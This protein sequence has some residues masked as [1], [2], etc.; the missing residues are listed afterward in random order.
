M[1]DLKEKYLQLWGRLT[2]RQHYMAVG[3]AVLLVVAIVAASFAFGGKPDMVPL[4]TNMETKDAG[5]VAAK[6]KENKVD[7]EVQETK[8]G[9]TIM[10][11]AAD[12]HD[13]RLSL[14]TEGLPR[15]NKG[16]EIFDDSKLGV[17]EFQ[18][19]VN[20]LQAL[21]G[22]LTR[23][24]EQIA[25][26]EK[27][28]V[29]IVLPEDSLYKRN[30]KPATASIMLKLRPN[31]ELNKKE[32]K[33]IVNLA[34]RSIQGLLPENITVVDETGRILNDPDD[35]DEENNI[36]QKTMTQLDMTRKV[37]ER[38]QKDVQTM[39][40]QALGEGHSYVRVNVELDFDQ[41]Q[42]DRQTYTPV[43]DDSGIIRS[44]Q[45]INETYSGTSTAPG[46]PAG[47]QSNVPGYVAEEN[48]SN[49]NYA[50]K[51]TTKNYEVNEAKEKTVA[52]PGSIKRV[53]IAVLV[54]EDI[55]QAQQESI[56][57]SVASAVGI[58]PDRGDTV[59][60]EPLPFSTEVADRRAAEE[61]AA[62]NAENMQIALIVGL[63]LLIIGGVA[64][65]FYW[66][67]KKR[68]EAEQAAMEEAMRKAE[69]ERLRA[70]AERAARLES[71]ELEPEEMTQEEQEHL[72]ERQTI[73][74]LIR[75]KPAEM[76]MLVKTW[77]SE[78]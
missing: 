64:G 63:I 44:E 37:Q 77:L 45:T 9:T 23:T 49:A 12:V 19:K 72:S 22:E 25:A 74:D 50:K 47:T 73:E 7:Y 71:G 20:Y 38:M 65:Y 42:T 70:E 43:V 2:K 41:R 28:R 13:A 36:T 18:N 5:E 56:Q 14:A 34:S 69:E 33:G 31:M 21:Q 3:G 26:V 59:S 75:N 17:T 66:K 27:A 61:Q 67:R 15:G 60:V 62:R 76:A 48:N 4:F 57:R 40:D 58:N 68:L 11:P 78:D 32:V 6:L 24:I 39:L 8:Q 51:E 52:S 55:T 54:N 16:F 30:E 46:G 1:G 35:E 29:H 10:V 53:N